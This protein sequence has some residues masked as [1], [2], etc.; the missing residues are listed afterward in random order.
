MRTIP[1]RPPVGTGLCLDRHRRVGRDLWQVRND[2]FVAADGRDGQLEPGQLRHR[3]GQWPGGDHHSIGL[4]RLNGRYH[5]AHALAFPE[6]ARDRLIGAEPGAAQARE[7][8]GEAT[9]L[10]PAIILAKAGVDDVR[11]EIRKPASRLTAIEKLDVR[12]TPPMLRSNEV[13]LHTCPG[14][15]TGD[16][17]ISLMP[18]AKVDALL[19]VVEERHAF[20][21][22]LDLL[23]VV[24]LQPKGARC[25]RRR[26]RRQRWT[27]LDQDRRESGPLRE[28]G[29]RATDDAPADDDEVGALGR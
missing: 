1:S 17:E 9:R 2:Q 14:L 24:E 11:R 25:N 8:E 6:K 12:Q 29:R 15:G 3:A 16:E 18:E 28:I 13:G 26:Q 10:E 22:Q 4:D 21:D 27:F 5:A 7:L 19:Q 20:A 23:G